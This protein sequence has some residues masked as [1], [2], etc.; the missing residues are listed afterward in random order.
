[1]TCHARINQT[2]QLTMK[3]EDNHVGEDYGGAIT[4]DPATGDWYTCS[5]LDEG[6][7]G[8]DLAVSRFNA[9]GQIAW[10]TSISTA[11]RDSCSGILLDTV[12]G[13]LYVSGATSGTIGGSVY[14]GGFSDA[15]MAKLS[16]AHG[17]LIS[18]STFGSIQDDS[19]TSLTFGRST[20]EVIAV[21]IT[22]GSSPT[23]DFEGLTKTGSMVFCHVLQA[24][25]SSLNRLVDLGAQAGVANLNYISDVR[26]TS[27]GTYLY[28]AGFGT[29]DMAGA[30]N[31]Q[32]YLAKLS[33]D[34]FVV[35]WMTTQ[36]SAYASSVVYNSAMGEVAVSGLIDQ[37]GGDFDVYL[38]R[39]NASTG[40]ELAL[41]SHASPGLDT[42]LT[43]TVDEGREAY[44]VLAAMYDALG[45]SY[46][47]V[48][49]MSYGKWIRKL[50][51][52]GIIG[53]L[54]DVP[55]VISNNTNNSNNNTGTDVTANSKTGPAKPV[56]TI[57]D[58]L[59]IALSVAGAVL[60]VGAAVGTV[61][62][63]R[64]HKVHATMPMTIV[65]PQSSFVSTVPS[66][67][68]VVSIQSEMVAVAAATAA[69]YPPLATSSSMASSYGNSEATTN[70]GTAQISMPTAENSSAPT[71]VSMDMTRV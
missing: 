34:T 12:A 14:R 62:A 20:S 70:V 63:M 53:G 13:F 21:G 22:A 35:L 9:Q 2:G 39:Y 15:L 56:S 61:Y 65:K 1:M 11:G 28:L 58:V 19:I 50:S 55:P 60:A 8:F 41:D 30:S 6:V 24:D 54:A 37:V 64:H 32:S 69:T 40:A 10:T 49:Q 45:N 42:A 26:A 57:S 67:S 17:T 46:G 18:A 59:I 3:Y 51:K 4:V 47:G 43:L 66:G 25:S 38:H 7:T 23:T 31:V 27:D 29:S 33:L 44:N 68:H 5:Y 71:T 36:S 16:T 48:I 52:R